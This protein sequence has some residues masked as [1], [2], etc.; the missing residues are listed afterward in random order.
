MRVRRSVTYARAYLMGVPA[1]VAEHVQP[2]LAVMVLWTAAIGWR[3]FLQGILIRFGQSRAVGYGTAVRLV[4]AAGTA[5]GLTFWPILPG[6]LVGARVRGSRRT[7]AV[8]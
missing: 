6:V 3:R 4:F 1:A 2:G 7:W 5:I 8:T